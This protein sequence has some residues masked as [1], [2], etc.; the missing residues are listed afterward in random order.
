MLHGYLQE[1]SELIFLLSAKFNNSTNIFHS[2][3]GK[4]VRW[5]NIWISQPLPELLNIYPGEQHM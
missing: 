1:I 3:D 2:L 4:G 5:R